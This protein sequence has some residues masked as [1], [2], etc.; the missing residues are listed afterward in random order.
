MGANAMF[1]QGGWLLLA[2]AAIAAGS[3]TYAAATVSRTALQIPQ[4]AQP[5]LE[6]REFIPL[7]GP[8]SQRP[9]QGECEPIILF[10]HEGQ[11]YQLRPG[12][13][14][15]QGS[16]GAPPEFY[17]MNPYQGPPIPGLP[18]PGLPFPQQDRGP[19]PSQPN[20]RS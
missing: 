4:P 12:P 11:L 6:M 1:K 13:K 15:G 5:S 3:V 18:A 9:Q 19:A 14:D 2:V 20:P 10:Y 7:P 17:Q 8:D 16:P